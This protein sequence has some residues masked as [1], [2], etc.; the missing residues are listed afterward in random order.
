MKNLFSKMTGIILSAGL[1]L[2]GYVLPAAAATDLRCRR[3]IIKMR[4][5]KSNEQFF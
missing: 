3:T 5:D 4:G 1:L 2:T